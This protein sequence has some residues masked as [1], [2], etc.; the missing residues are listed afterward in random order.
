MHALNMSSKIWIVRSDCPSV[1]GWN[2]VLNFRCVPKLSC[3]LCQYCNLNL[4]SLSDTILAGT[5]CRRTTSC[6]YPSAKDSVDCPTLNGM[7]WADLVDRSTIT[8]TALFPYGL[9]GKAVT[10]SMVILSHFHTGI[11]NGCK[12][13]AGFWCSA[14]TCWHIK[15]RDTYRA[16]S[17]FIP[18]HQK[19][20]FRSWYIFVPPG[21]ME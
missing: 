16:I 3:R 15:H 1:W 21:C 8:Q 17:R 4:E 18:F 2:E 20:V 9:R 12:S 6:M 13:P 7:K 5:P 19:C 14:L 10:K 11:G